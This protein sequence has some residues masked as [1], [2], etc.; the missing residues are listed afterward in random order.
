[1]TRIVVHRPDEPTPPPVAVVLAPREKVECP[2]VGLVSNGKPHAAELLE[3]IAREL[4]A[5]LGPGEV[6][7]LRKPSAAYTI[8]PAQARDMAARA[9]LVV[10]GVG[11]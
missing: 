10:T 6:E 9:H 7:L 3:A 11:D 2:V 1:M 8:T 4:H 5:R